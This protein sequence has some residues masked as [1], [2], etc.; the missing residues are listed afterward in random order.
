MFPTAFDGTRPV[1]TVLKV[2]LRSGESF[3][4]GLA[5][6][7]YGHHN[8]VPPW[9]E[10]EEKRILN[11]S[12]IKEA[13]APKDLLRVRDFSRDRIEQFHHQYYAS[14]APKM[15]MDDIFDLMNMD[16]LRWQK[17]NLS[18]ETTLG[19]PENVFHAKQM[20]VDDY[21]QWRFNFPNAA[22]DVYKTV[23]GAELRRLNKN[24][25]GCPEHNT[26]AT[27]DI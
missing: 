7:Q 16:I 5:G 27:R 24:G 1:H 3:S 8:P 4:V 14:N 13:E 12:A 20:D 21:I 17:E 2:T 25:K 23:R 11:V 19:L 9:K 22:P 15:I 10:F 26:F 6:A 18:L